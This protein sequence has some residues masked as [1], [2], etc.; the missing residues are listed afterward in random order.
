MQYGFCYLTPYTKNNSKGMKG[1]KVRPETTDLQKEKIRGKLLDISLGHDI[2]NQMPMSRAKKAKKKKKDY[3]KL[4][5][6][7]QQRKPSTK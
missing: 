6:F 4:N 2:L 7:A 5:S 3:I 1:L